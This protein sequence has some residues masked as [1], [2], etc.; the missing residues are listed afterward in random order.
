MISPIPT[1]GIQWLHGEQT[2]RGQ[3]IYVNIREATMKVVNVSRNPHCRGVHT[4]APAEPYA[5]PVQGTNTIATLLGCVRELVGEA[6]IPLPTQF[7]MRIAC[8]KCGRLAEPRVPVWRWRLSPL[9]VDC[10]G[11]F[12]LAAAG[13]AI[14]AYGLLETEKHIHD[15]VGS[16]TCAEAGLAPGTTLEAFPTSPHSDFGAYCL[17]SLAGDIDDLMISLR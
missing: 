4:L 9:C 11:P 8:T 1:A 13:K 16:V 17:L 3:R 7:A 5:I 12:P 14:N 10:G 6:T 15:E 2:R